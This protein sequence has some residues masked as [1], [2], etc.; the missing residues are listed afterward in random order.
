MENRGQNKGWL[1]TFCFIKNRE[2]I[3]EDYTRN[4]EFV[5]NK[6]ICSVVV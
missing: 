5:E 4:I 6:R 3:M 2:K 1:L